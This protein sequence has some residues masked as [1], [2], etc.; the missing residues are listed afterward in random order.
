MSI[1]SFVKTFS[2]TSGGNLNV[3]D[4]C[5]HST[6]SARHA[7][8]SLTRCAARDHFVLGARSSATHPCVSQKS[9]LS[10]FMQPHM[11]QITQKQEPHEPYLQQHEHHRPELIHQQPV[12]LAKQCGWSGRMAEQSSLTEERCCHRIIRIFFSKRATE[13]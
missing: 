3:A 11:P 13:D 10:Q 12:H 9:S 2:P 1:F 4:G 7:L 6:L 8:P 5:V